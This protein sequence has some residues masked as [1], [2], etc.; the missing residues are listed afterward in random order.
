MPNESWSFDEQRLKSKP[1]VM[2]VVLEI[3]DLFDTYKIQLF[4]NCFI[5]YGMS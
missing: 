1:R 2:H 5:E 4:D 3:Y